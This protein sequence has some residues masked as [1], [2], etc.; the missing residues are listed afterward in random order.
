MSTTITV[1]ETTLNEAELA[2][3]AKFDAMNPKAKKP[4]AEFVFDASSPEDITL[5]IDKRTFMNAVGKSSTEAS[6]GATISFSGNFDYVLGGKTYTFSA[7]L[8]G[9]WTTVKRVL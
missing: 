2:L 5:V 8:R 3:A 7:T 6:E 4:R 9:G 1:A